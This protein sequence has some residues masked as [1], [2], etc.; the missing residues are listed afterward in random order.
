MLGS[1]LTGLHVNMTPETTA[2]TM[3]CTVTPIAA[4]VTPRFAR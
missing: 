1:P 2:S 4:S 3:V